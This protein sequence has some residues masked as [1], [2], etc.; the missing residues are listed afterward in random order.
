MKCRMRNKNGLEVTLSREEMAALDITYEKLDYANTETR[1]VLW[2]VLDEAE[3]VL[4]CSFDLSGKMRIEARPNA[5]GGC[6]LDFTLQTEPTVPR[7]EKTDKRQAALLFETDNADDLLAAVK[8]LPCTVG[9]DLYIH[10]NRFRLLSAATFSEKEQ[11]CAILTEFGT[12]D[13]NCTVTSAQTREYWSLVCK[14][15]VGLLQSYC[16]LRENTDVQN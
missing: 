13:E 14:N 4:G 16:L 5:D 6:I 3:S 9:G 12:V 7:H 15:A 10:K 2:T 11:L 8:H 1:R